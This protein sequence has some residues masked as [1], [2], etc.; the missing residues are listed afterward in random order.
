[1]FPPWNLRPARGRRC[2]EP[3]GRLRGGCGPFPEDP[4]D[5]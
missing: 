5:L 2:A 1:M 3:L 4:A